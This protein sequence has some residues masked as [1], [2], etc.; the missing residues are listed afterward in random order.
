[1]AA[2]G[3][4]ALMLGAGCL[5]QAQAPPQ[6][7]G[8]FQIQG[9]VRVIDGDTLEIFI[10][11]RQTAV[12][13]IGI[14]APWGNTTCGQ[15]AIATLRALIRNGGV[16]TLVEDPNIT[17]DARKRRL[18]YV[19]LPGNVSAAVQLALAGVVTQNNQGNQNEQGDI[20]NAYNSAVAA[21][22]GCARNQNQQ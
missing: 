2:G 7:S 13:V 16:F 15:T 5:L 1:M 14:K 8:N 4:L 10:N 3:V 18:Y 9:P 20:Q 19:K 22:R 12:G 21:G 11:G 6:G 17:F